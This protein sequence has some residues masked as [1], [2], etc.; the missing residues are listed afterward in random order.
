M[1][2]DMKVKDYVA[3]MQ[4][5]RS[6]VKAKMDSAGIGKVHLSFVEHSGRPK[7][8]QV[9]AIEGYLNFEGAGSVSQLYYLVMSR[10][11]RKKYANSVKTA[12][13]TGSKYPNAIWDSNGGSS[14]K[15]DANGNVIKPC[16]YY[17]VQV[18]PG[19]KSDIVLQVMEGEG[20]VTETGGYMLKK[21]ATVKRINVPF[22]FLDFCAFVVD[23]HDAVAAYKS[24]HAQLGYTG[25]E[26][27][28]FTP[29]KPRNAV[30][31]EPMNTTATM[32]QAMPQT[33]VPAPVATQQ[34]AEKLS[35]VFVMYD[36]LGKTMQ[37]TD[38]AQNV[39]TM[40]GKMRK[41]LYKNTPEHYALVNDKYTLEAVQSALYS[42]A[43]TIPTLSLIH[44]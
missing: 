18:S 8:E 3:Q 12:R 28:E 38:S 34:N 1:A 5:G 41:A 37:V 21:G 25:S 23:I 11:I 39:M 4:S 9:A 14:E 42:G 33:P 2:K 20:E 32:P 31:Q 29:Y 7:C 27:N 43:P 40:F 44:I 16:R 30:Q 15:R 35:V 19:S 17:A 10:D 36:S 22:T 24:V 26:I 6:F 13:E